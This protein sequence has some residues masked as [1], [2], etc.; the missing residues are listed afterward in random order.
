MLGTVLRIFFKLMN[1]S[2]YGKTMK[3]SRKRIK[4]KLVYNARDY[5][6]YVGRPS[7]VLKKIFNQNL[8]AINS[9]KPVLTL[10]KLIY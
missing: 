1:N 3:N 8:V 2:V 6:K 4:V 7:F 5:N 9:I 10:G